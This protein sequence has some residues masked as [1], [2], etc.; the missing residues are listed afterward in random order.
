[1]AGSVSSFR[2]QQLHHGNGT[3]CGQRLRAGV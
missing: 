3:L 2:R 1:M